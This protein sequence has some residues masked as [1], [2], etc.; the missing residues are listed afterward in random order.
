MILDFFEVFLWLSFGSLIMPLPNRCPNDEGGVVNVSISPKLLTEKLLNEALLVE[1]KLTWLLNRLLLVGR[2]AGGVGGGA[3][4]TLRVFG[5]EA[6]YS[7][8]SL[9][10]NGCRVC[11]RG[12]EVEG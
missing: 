8:L 6:A 5:R 12:A 2:R 3:C 7:S 1:S 4:D 9:A 11:L 10:T